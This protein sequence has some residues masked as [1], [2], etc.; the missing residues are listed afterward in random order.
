MSEGTGV[1]L[2]GRGVLRV[3]GPDARHFL[4]NLL[5]NDLDTVDETGA[6]HGA[7]LTPQ[8]KILFAFLVAR[9]RDAQD[10]YLLESDAQ[11][12]AELARRL[13]F[14]KLRSKVEI[15]DISDTTSV[16][17]LWGADAPAA[18]GA[19][20]RAVVFADPRLAAMGTRVL[21]DH[22][23][24]GAPDAIEGFSAAPESAYH[25]RRVVFC[26]PEA[27]FDF[28]LGEAFPHDVDMDQLGGVAFDKGCFVGQE[29]V[30][31]MQHRGTARRR[32]V[33]VSAEDDL[34]E[35]GAEILAGDKPAGTLGTVSGTRAL[36]LLRLDRI[37]SAR[38]KGD[39]ITCNGLP[40]EATLPEWASF[41]W[42]EVSGAEGGA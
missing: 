27:P 39:E 42:P 31:R 24:A 26:V 35:S 1:R 11:S 3:C 37:A 15:T 19:L 22:G 9:A 33:K 13:R 34:P 7:L 25:T 28:A 41:A 16:H 5:T 38:A 14:Y 2:S 40:I 12:L 32:I 36:A 29:V 10:A 20:A 18:E 4:Q 30:S 6:G 8:G 23:E 17:A 21:L